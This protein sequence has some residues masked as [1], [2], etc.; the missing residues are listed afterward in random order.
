M[1]VGRTLPYHITEAQMLLYM[2]TS[3][4]HDTP[5]TINQLKNKIKSQKHTPPK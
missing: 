5:H 3:I 1:S 4:L 2:K